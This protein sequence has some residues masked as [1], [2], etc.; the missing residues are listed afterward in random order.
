MK[1]KNII[2]LFLPLLF[3]GIASFASN[4]SNYLYDKNGQK[5]GLWTERISETLTQIVYYKHGQ[6]D[7]IFRILNTHNSQLYVI[8][9]MDNGEMCGT[10]LYFDDDNHL[11][12]K[13]EDFH[14]E[15]TCIPSLHNYSIKYAPQNCYC[16]LFYNNGRIKGRGRL[17]FFEDPQMDDSGEYGLWEFFDEIG[18]LIKTCKYE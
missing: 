12:M 3:M 9:E 16:T 11:L 18:N 17:F 8:G 4:G 5:D 7:G 13:C 10:W 1:T 14:K 6:E 2:G 15:K